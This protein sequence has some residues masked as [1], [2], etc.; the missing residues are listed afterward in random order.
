MGGRLTDQ[1]SVPAPWLSVE[2]MTELKILL[3][4]VAFLLT[5]AGPLHTSWHKYQA[6]R[7]KNSLQKL[8]AQE[9]E[10]MDDLVRK[11][12]ETAGHWQLWKTVC[13]V[14]GPFLALIV[15]ILF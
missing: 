15:S 11:R 7:V 1:P 4:T 9:D 5:V 8:G 10:I 3:H 12:H 6:Y 13:T 2:C 14:G